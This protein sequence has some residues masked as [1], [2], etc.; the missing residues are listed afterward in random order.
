MKVLDLSTIMSVRLHHHISSFLLLNFRYATP[1]FYAQIYSQ[2]NRYFLSILLLYIVVLFYL[3]TIYSMY[4]YEIYY[5]LYYSLFYFNK[6]AISSISSSVFLSSESNLS[7]LLSIF[8]K[9]D[10]SFFRLDTSSL[11][12]ISLIQAVTL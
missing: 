4:F 7:N 5:L 6:A 11:L 3:T 1:H 10:S 8:F 9:S 2:G 12:L